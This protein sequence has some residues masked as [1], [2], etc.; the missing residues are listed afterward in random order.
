MKTDEF[1][2]AYDPFEGDRDTDVQMRKV[3]IVTARKEHDCQLGLGLD[4]QPH[5]IKVGERAR[6]ESG[7]VDGAWCRYY[8]CLKCL[9]KIIADIQK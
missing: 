4:S 2:L 8:V 9:D 1:Y 7:L 5:K 6:R 3:R